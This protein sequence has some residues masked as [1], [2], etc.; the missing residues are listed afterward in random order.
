MTVMLFAA[1][2]VVAMKPIAIGIIAIL[3][4][5]GGIYGIAIA[6]KQDREAQRS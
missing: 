1:S 4:L 3:S 2:L 5:L 6:V